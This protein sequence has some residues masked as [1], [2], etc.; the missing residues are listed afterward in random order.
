MIAIAPEA[1]PLVAMAA[2]AVAAACALWLPARLAAFWGAP[3]S[4]VATAAT[5]LLLPPVR[6]GMAVEVTPFEILPDLSLS[7]RVDALGITFALLA[8]GLWV[9]TSVYAA[10]YAAA[11]ALKHRP[12]FFAAFAASIGAT[13]GIAFAGDLLT[14]FVFY[15]L[16]TVTTYPLVVHKETERAYA[17]GRRYLL[18]ALGGGL[19]MLTAVAWTWQLTGTLAFRPGGFI[20]A[21]TAPPVLAALFALFVGGVAVK[22]A[23][24]PAHAWLPMAMVAPTPVSALLHAVAVVKA[25]VFGTMRVLGFVLGPDALGTIRGTEVLAVLAVATI[26]AGSVIALRQENL[27]RRLAYSTIVHLA[28]IVLGVALVSAESLT[29]AV[30]HMVNH[31]LAKITLFFCAGAIFVTTHREN[32]SDLAGL[33]RRMPWTFGA[34]TVASLAL[35]GVPGLAGFPGK[36]LL[37]RGALAVGD[38]VALT[39]MLGASLLTAAYLLPIVRLAYFPGPRERVTPLRGTATVASDP[40]R[41]HEAPAS[42]V[43]PLVV[44]A[45]LAIAF[46]ALP[47]V[48]GAQFALA[49]EVAR[50]VFGGAP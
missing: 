13:L 50:S 25:G 45:G 34:F 49:A 22:S 11:D 21:A 47:S 9:A 38:L 5:A 36:F 17:A 40:L 31:G 29:G 48:M 6:A 27:K 1:L 43:V 10:G 14:F 19:L 16:L 20:P 39:V 18:F 23:V 24:M 42:M 44:T 32:V 30:L 35:I 26:L 3:A 33:G 8:S 37:A 2:P 12:R 7:L 15:E 28:Y 41:R 4:V 46:G